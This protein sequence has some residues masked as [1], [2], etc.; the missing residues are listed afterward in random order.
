MLTPETWM[1]S[2]QAF[3]S[4]GLNLKELIVSVLTSDAFLAP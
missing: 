4:A 1:P 3:V 2:F